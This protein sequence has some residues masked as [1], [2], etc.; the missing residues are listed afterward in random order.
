G[1]ATGCI[2]LAQQT[3]HRLPTHHAKPNTGSAP[4]TPLRHSCHQDVEP[5]EVVDGYAIAGIDNH[6]RRVRLDDRR[7]CDARTLLQRIVRMNPPLAPPAE[8][9]LALAC[10]HAGACRNFV[11]DGIRTLRNDTDCG[12]AR[13]HENNFLIRRGVG[14]QFFV[15]TVK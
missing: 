15:T 7:S 2:S 1:P 13:I 3:S 8:E 12:E 5:T 9:R 11:T 14:V 6:G 10:W 4:S